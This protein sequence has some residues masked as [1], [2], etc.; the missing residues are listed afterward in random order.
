MGT[1]EQK[2]Q[3][4]LSRNLLYRILSEHPSLIPEVL[5]SVWKQFYD[6]RDTVHL[7]SAAETKSA[8]R[9]IARK[10][11]QIGKFCFFIDG[12]DEFVGNYLDGMDFLK[13]LAANPHI[14]ILVSSRPI[15]D[16]VASF[17]GLPSL[18]LHHLTRADIRAYVKETI[19][20]HRYMQGLLNRHP[21]EA[22][23]IMEDLVDKSS[24]VFLWVRLACRSLISGFAD[25]DRI[26]ELQRRV[27]ELPPEL[28]EM[29][30]HML[31]R[32]NKRHR[33]QGSRML[34]ICFVAQ[35]A[36]GK[37]RYRDLALLGLALIDD[38]YTSVERI[39]AL[40]RGQKR[41]LCEELEGRLRSRTGG[42]L[43]THWEAGGICL[44]DGKYCFCGS[45]SGGDHDTKIDAKVVFMHRSVFEFLSNEKSW[46]LECLRPPEGL[47]PASELSL[48]GL[49]LTMTS[50]PYYSYQA[51]LF[52]Q[53]GL[54]W[55]GQFDSQYPESKS[56]IFWVIQP[57]IDSLK[58]NFQRE[59]N[60][61]G[62]IAR[63]GESSSVVVD[64]AAEVGAINYVKTH[65][66]FPQNDSSKSE[67]RWST[68]LYHTVALPLI[69]GDFS[70]WIN[71]YNPELFLDIVA[72][73]IS[74]GGDL[75]YKIFD[76]VKTRT[77]TPWLKWLE[78]TL[79][80]IMDESHLLFLAEVGEIFLRSGADISEHFR[81]WVQLKFQKRNCPRIRQAGAKL[82]DL[83]DQL[84]LENAP[85]YPDEA[86]EE[87]G[88]QDQG[89][90]FAFAGASPHFNA[91]RQPNLREGRRCFPRGLSQTSAFVRSL[92]R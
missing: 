44:Q 24:G 16:C 53:D 46:D 5:P 3:E 51:T 35:Q 33:E 78:S 18:E 36:H 47:Q 32:I 34:R 90:G 91:Q 83:A 14:K 50:T 15:P 61:L 21:E 10:A 85:S 13:E 84:E 87:S 59:H 23:T 86:E 37:L 58:L 74:Q 57:F 43:E 22:T 29:F 11:S 26:H 7:P 60:M 19:G 52:L 64:L 65:I 45:K 25:Y 88:G 66:S 2:S 70:E 42:L 38:D 39:S 28:E 79:W 30:Q 49:Y 72:L 17:S 76:T 56:N 48:I 62:R 12:L 20:G 75:N 41:T 68:L 77:T 81:H 71:I 54:H 9:V 80:I 69:S 1:C 4:G 82:L 92:P 6:N 67:D 55:G 89:K 40:S 8:F 63:G 73:L 31:N 27:D